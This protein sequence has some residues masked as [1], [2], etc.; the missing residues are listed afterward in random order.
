MERTR[1][2]LSPEARRAE[3][4]AVTQAAIVEVGYR[5]LSLREIARRCDMS[6][7]GL[8]HYFS[9]LPT[10]LAAVLERRDQLDQAAIIERVPG[11]TLLETLD[12][13]WRYYN[14]RA[15]EVRSF[16]ALEAEALDP[17]HPAHAYFLRRDARIF[18]ILGEIIER[19]FAD[20]ETV[21]RLVRLLLAGERVS[22]LLDSGLDV[23]NDWAVIERVID[24]QPRRVERESD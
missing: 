1:R 8:M 19:E 13:V 16:D 12:E 18:A 22:R 11:A 23:A 24:A 3:I 10:L 5:S 17:G 7:P 6:T 2:R 14:E 4:L 20:P 9:D 15:D 21:S